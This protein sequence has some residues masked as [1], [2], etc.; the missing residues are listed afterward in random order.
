MLEIQKLL[1]SLN[2]AAKS[3]KALTAIAQEKKDNAEKVQKIAIEET[4]AVRV[5]EKEIK[6]KKNLILSTED[7]ERREKDLDQKA[8]FLAQE[9]KN[10]DA[11][12]ADRT[13]ELNNAEEELVIKLR[14]L[15]E[16]EEKLEKEKANYKKKI[17]DALD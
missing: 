11:Q 14:G 16:K 17:M 3:L 8:T 13:V 4:Q 6:K 7:L 12:C 2:D 15:K 9:R 1:T 10:F 5:K